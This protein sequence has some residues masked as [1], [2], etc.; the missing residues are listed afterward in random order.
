MVLEKTLES[1]L[2]CEEIQLVHPKGDQSWVFIGRTDA[3]AETPILW[4]PH[5]KSW[6]IGEDPNA[7][8]DRGQEE[9]GLTEDEMAG[10]HHRLN[11]NEFERTPGVGDGQGDLACCDSQ[12][13]KESDMTE[14][15]NW[16]KG[17]S[18]QPWTL[19][20]SQ[21]FAYSTQQCVALSA[22]SYVLG[23][24][25]IHE[26]LRLHP[27]L[28]WLSWQHMGSPGSSA[29]SF[30]LQCRWPQFDSWVGKF[31]W[32]PRL[33]TLVFLYFPGGS[34]DKEFACI[35][36]DLGLIPGLGR[37]PG[38]GHGNPLHHSCLENPHGQRSL[39]GCSPWGRKSRTHLSTAQLSIQHR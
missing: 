21:M 13:C 31:P 38:A 36:G 37:T 35:A 12:G 30:H 9:K 39:V 10:W 18:T 5:W 8:K 24:I 6:L 3:E 14:W 15:L 34:D 20:K 16:T 17:I 22:A 7:G 1:P 26:N 19:I 23:S 11:G 32:R 2:D 33:P 29:G 27:H 4:P 25:L 28:N